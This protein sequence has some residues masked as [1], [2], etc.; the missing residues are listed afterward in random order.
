MCRNIHT[1]YNVDPP[2]TQEEIHLAALQYV[3]KV[4]GY[5]KPSRVNEAVFM[6]AVNEIAEASTRL[7]ASL[8]TNAEVKD[9]RSAHG[10]PSRLTTG[11]TTSKD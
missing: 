5:N 4:S 7:I 3:R 11:S 1:L 2:V 9:R 6:A 10:N 8:Q